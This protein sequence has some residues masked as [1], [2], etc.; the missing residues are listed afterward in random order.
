MSGIVQALG[1]IA[2]L[3]DRAGLTGSSADLLTG[4]GDHVG[5]S[6]QSCLQQTRP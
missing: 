4:V 6:G 5:Q 3:P 2:S 1:S